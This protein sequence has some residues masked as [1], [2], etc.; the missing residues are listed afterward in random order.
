MEYDLWERPA[1][2]NG[3]LG[4][5]VQKLDGSDARAIVASNGGSDL[6]YVP[7][8]NADTVREITNLLL[9]YDYVGGIFVDDKFGSLPGTLPLSAINLVGSKTPDQVFTESGSA[10]ATRKRGRR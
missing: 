7:D 9:T 5:D 8:G 6:V 1:S 3:L 2:G 4:D 10:K